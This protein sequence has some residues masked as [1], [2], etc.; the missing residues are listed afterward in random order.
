MHKAKVSVPKIFAHAVHTHTHHS[1][2]S[3]PPL[4]N[5]VWISAWGYRIASHRTMTTIGT[6]ALS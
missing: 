1:Y 3:Q 2:Y 5:F 4:L 6:I